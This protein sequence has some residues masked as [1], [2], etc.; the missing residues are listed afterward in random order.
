MQAYKTLIFWPV[1]R[2]G[3]FNTDG[4]K[5]PTAVTAAP[6]HN[7]IFATLLRKVLLYHNWTTVSFLCD[8]NYGYYRINCEN[9][10]RQLVAPI[11]ESHFV[12]F[13]SALE[14]V[15]FSS[16]LDSVRKSARGSLSYSLDG[17][18]YCFSLKSNDEFVYLSSRL[19]ILLQWERQENFGVALI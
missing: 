2:L 13:D 19:L 16:Y 8:D 14:A 1:C 3:S 9:S 7:A 5:Y 4:T 12:N 17:Q 6:T 11:F 18:I 15:N 10:K